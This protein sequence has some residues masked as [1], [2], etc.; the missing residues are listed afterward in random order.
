MELDALVEK[1]SELTSIIARMSGDAE[2]K[3]GEGATISWVYGKDLLVTIKELSFQEASFGWQTWSGGALFAY[4]ISIGKIPV[5]NE[6]ILELGCGTG[7]VGIMACKMGA[8]HV[9]MTDYHH[10][11]LESTIQNIKSNNCE[12]SASAHSLDWT[13]IAEGSPIQHTANKVVEPFDISEERIKFDVI[14]GADICY[15]P[16]HGKLVP[17]VCERFISDSPNAKVYFVT[18][19]RREKFAQDIS[20]FENQMEVFGFR[21]DY[22]EDISMDQFLESSVQLKSDL[23]EKRMMEG[24][25][26]SIFKGADPR[27]RFYVYSRVPVEPKFP[28]K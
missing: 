11:V 26:K 10:R 6:T 25:A 8:K 1:I 23:L 20:F 13:W 22:S 27:F 5:K 21:L 16:I 18:G 2:T 19:L 7:I 14:L 4:L 28:S 12:S 15:D 24:L 9:Y 3:D 17:P